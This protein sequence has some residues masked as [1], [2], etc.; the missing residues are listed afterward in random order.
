MWWE[1]VALFSHIFAEKAEGEDFLV[2]GVPYEEKAETIWH[3]V[4]YPALV[5]NPKVTKITCVHGYDFTRRRV[6]DNGDNEIQSQDT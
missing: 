4:E 6:I 1:Y 5:N 3:D 2:S